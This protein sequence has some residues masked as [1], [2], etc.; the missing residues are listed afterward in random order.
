MTDYTDLEKQFPTEFSK[1]EE[2]KKVQKM[3][4][5]WDM[6]NCRICGRSISMLKAKMSL[7]GNGFVCEGACK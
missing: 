1:K 5:E 4:E 7:D 3:I 6:V 2:D